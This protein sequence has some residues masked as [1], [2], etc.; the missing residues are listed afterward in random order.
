MLPLI[1]SYKRGKFLWI[2]GFSVILC[3]GLLVVFRLVHSS[4]GSRDSNKIP[5]TMVDVLTVPRTDL[6][7]RI[8][9]TGQT[10]PK[11]QVDISAKYQGKIVAVNAELGQPVTTGQVLIEQ[12]TGDAELAIAQNQAAYQQATADAINSDVAFRANYNRAKAD[13]DR[14]LASYRRYKT[15]YEAGGIAK[16]ALDTNEQ[17]MIDAKATLDSLV[18]QMNA[19]SVPATVEAAR[20]AAEKAQHGVSAAEKQRNDLILRAPFSGVIGYRQAEIGSM[21][22]AGQKLMTVVDNSKIFVD[23]QVSEQDLPALSTGME[24]NVQLEALSREFPGKIIY[25]SPASD[26]SNLLFS[27]RIDLTN[28]APDIKGGMF[29]RTVIQS[30]LRPRVLVVP[31]TAILDK[32]GKSYVF[33]IDDQNVAEERAV[34]IGARG[35]QNV[36][37]LEGLQEG[38]KIAVSNLSRLRSGLKI[39]ANPVALDNRGDSQ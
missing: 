10:V 5:Q 19:H 11:A 39:K 3:L 38:E 2:A 16:D 21:V 24:V 37:I 30:V 6:L 32:N 12:D 31:K 23:C 20:A 35:D 36:E 29:A 15:L 26:S 4:S 9:L 33:V 22:T 17:Q 27:L 28:P 25:I 34:E 1:K 7:K 13:Y 14:A 8:S 18:N